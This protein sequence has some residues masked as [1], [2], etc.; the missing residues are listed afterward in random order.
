MQ[1][2]LLIS[3]CVRLDIF[4]NPFPYCSIS[5]IFFQSL[6]SNKLFFFPTL[7]LLF[8][9]QQF[10][11]LYDFSSPNYF[12]PYRYNSL[13]PST[14][15]YLSHLTVTL[16]VFFQPFPLFFL[17]FFSPSFY[18]LWLQFFQLFLSFFNSSSSTSYFL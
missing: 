8:L 13:N 15:S 7:P 2:I 17:L 1:S 18:T 11:F 5:A 3:H 12:I 16:L 9:I 10:L 6:P 14:S 4:S